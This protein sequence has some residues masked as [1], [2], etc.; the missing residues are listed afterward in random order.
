MHLYYSLNIYNKN[1]ID[2]NLSLLYLNRT[3]VTM[4]INL[5]APKRIVCIEKT[6]LDRFR[7][8]VESMKKPKLFKS[9]LI[10]KRGQKT[11]VKYDPK[12]KLFYNY[13][14]YEKDWQRIGDQRIMK[15]AL[16]TIK[17]NDKLSPFAICVRDVQK[18]Y[19]ELT[20]LDIDDEVYDEL[21]SEAMIRFQQHSHTGN[22]VPHEDKA[23]SNKRRYTVA[24]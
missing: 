9:Y 23:S 12:T 17:K 7:K 5:T 18:L 13:S 3:R 22:H 21:I 10:D 24:D 14:T 2:L 4:D 11:K 1:K 20:G 6:Q 15:E 8:E 16:G 19:E